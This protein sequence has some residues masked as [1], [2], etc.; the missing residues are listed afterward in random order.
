MIPIGSATET[1]WLSGMME[2]AGIEP[3]YH[4]DRPAGLLT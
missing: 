4:S 1:A 3:A 2:A